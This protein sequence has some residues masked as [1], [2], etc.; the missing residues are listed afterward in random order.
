MSKRSLS[1]GAGLLAA[2]SVFGLTASLGHSRGGGEDGYGSCGH[3]CGHSDSYGSTGRHGKKGLRRLRWADANGDG[4]VTL[5]QFTARRE[6]RF[7][8]LNADSDGELLLEELFKPMQVGADHKAR[9]IMTRYDAD[10]DGKITKDAF[11]KPAPR[12]FAT[13]DFNGDGKIS[14]DELPYRSWQTR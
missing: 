7:V 2:L 9:R 6:R 5:E 1:I 14:E 11:I 8:E 12:R 13:R 3:G 4:K 10:G